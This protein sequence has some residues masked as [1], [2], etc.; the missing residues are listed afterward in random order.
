MNTPTVDDSA[1]GVIVSSVPGSR[2][3]AVVIAD[4]NRAAHFTAQPFVP[5]ASHILCTTVYRTGPDAQSEPQTA[6]VEAHGAAKIVSHLAEEFNVNNR[7]QI[8]DAAAVAEWLQQANDDVPEPD[9]APY[10]AQRRHIWANPPVLQFDDQGRITNVTDD[11]YI[12]ATSVHQ[13]RDKR[14]GVTAFSFLGLGIATIYDVAHRGEWEECPDPDDPEIIH[15][16]ARNA[17]PLLSSHYSISLNKIAQIEERQI[18]G[19]SRLELN[20]LMLNAPVS[21]TGA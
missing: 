14:R 7:A 11:V 15:R 13:L 4:D 21:F 5:G 20:H 8:P 12:T 10:V 19:A 3:L 16:R 6:L 17:W 9:W 18:A 1:H 2:E